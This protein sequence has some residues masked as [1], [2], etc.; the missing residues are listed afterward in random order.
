MIDFL[1]TGG[2][3]ALRQKTAKLTIKQRDL[4]A[5]EYFRIATLPSL[6]EVD[7]ALLAK[8]LDFALI[9][10]DLDEIIQKCDEFYNQSNLQEREGCSDTNTNLREESESLTKADLQKLVAAI[11]TEEYEI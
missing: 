3:L 8:I 6:T 7:A 4:L 2:L 10:D 9:D 11:S 5:K 1:T